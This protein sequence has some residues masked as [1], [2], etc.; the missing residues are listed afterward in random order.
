[1]TTLWIGIDPGLTGAVAWY[2]DR[3]HM[4]VIDTPTVTVTKGKSRKPRLVPAEMG[5][6][7]HGTRTANA[8]EIADWQLT[9]D[10]IAVALE[11]GIAMP[12][13]SSTSTFA[14]GRGIGTWE[15]ILAGIGWPYTLVAPA[16]W[17]KALGIPAG[18][19]KGASRLLAA[20]LFPELASEVCRVRDDGR[21]EALLIMEWRRRQG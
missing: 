12:R 14:T 4:G 8:R 3:D 21:A 17:K 20:R 1:M 16:T 19:D 18:S 10:E 7:L 9:P 11:E 5:R 6:V 13:Q 2:L 15:G